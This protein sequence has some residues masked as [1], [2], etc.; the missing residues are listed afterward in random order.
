MPAGL[1]QTDSMFSV[2]EV[3]WHGLGAVLDSPPSTIAEAIELSGLGWEADRTGH[4][5]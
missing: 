2:R 5:V 1:T 3:P 4:G